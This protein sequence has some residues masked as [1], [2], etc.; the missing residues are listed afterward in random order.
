[1]PFG[2]ERSLLVRGEA[3]TLGDGS[4]CSP[5]MW[6]KSGAAR[7]R[8][9]VHIGDGGATDNLVEIVRGPTRCVM[10]ATYTEEEGDG[11]FRS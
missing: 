10:E 5:M 2:P 4:W 3:V 7:H 6:A 8:K 9:Y 11:R 1:M